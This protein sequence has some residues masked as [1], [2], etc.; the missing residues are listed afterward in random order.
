[1]EPGI[2][3][4]DMPMLN[5]E[6]PRAALR[7]S[8]LDRLCDLTLTLAREPEQLV[9]TLTYMKGSFPE[10]VVLLELLLEVRRQACELHELVRGGNTARSA[11]TAEADQLLAALE[12]MKDAAAALRQAAQAHEAVV[13]FG[14]AIQLQGK[15]AVMECLTKMLLFELE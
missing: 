14:K 5:A 4:F 1:V 12:Q 11:L 9:P 10:R 15:I 13:T 7:R 2:E 6:K 8:D 3:E